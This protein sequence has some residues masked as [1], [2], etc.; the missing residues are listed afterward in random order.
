MQRT[1]HLWE[2]WRKKSCDLVLWV[3]GAVLYRWRKFRSTTYYGTT[4]RLWALHQNA[5]LGLFSGYSNRFSQLSQ[6]SQVSFPFTVVPATGASP[7]KHLHSPSPLAAGACSPLQHPFLVL[8]KRKHRCPWKWW[9]TA[10]HCWETG[11]GSTR[12]PWGK[13]VSLHSRLVRPCSTQKD[14]LQAFLLQQQ[15]EYWLWHQKS[16]SKNWLCQLHL[17]FQIL[18]IASSTIWGLWILLILRKY[19]CRCF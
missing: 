14:F 2:L 18:L 17:A 6:G 13:A 10:K 16:K 8:H 4:F 15:E 7:S 11:K 12:D 19:L 1:T 3:P 9:F 5:T